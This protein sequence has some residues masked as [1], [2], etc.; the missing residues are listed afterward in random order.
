MRILTGLQQTMAG[1][2]R[3]A[4]RRVDA[5]LCILSLCQPELALDPESLN[6]RLNRLEEQIANGCTVTAPAKAAPAQPQENEAEAAVFSPAEPEPVAEVVPDDAPVGF[7][8]EV[9]AAVRQELKPPVLGFFSASDTAPV[10]GKLEGDTLVLYCQNDFA[11]N[12][13]N[14]PEVLDLVAR[15]ASAQLHRSVKV[16]AVD[17]KSAGGKNENME[18]LLNFGRSHSNIVTIKE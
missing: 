7:W 3:N 14:K 9:A 1:F 16:R 18:R 13:V 15:K 8:L 4:S 12:M 2:V 17:A 11:L 6:A 5:E 10:Q